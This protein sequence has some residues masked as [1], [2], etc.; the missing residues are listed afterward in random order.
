MLLA[1]ETMVE[2]NLVAVH[3]VIGGSRVLAPVVRGSEVTLY[4]PG[5]G[6]GILAVA[7]VL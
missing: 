6:V 7:Q 1:E 2:A 3:A 5:D 4:G